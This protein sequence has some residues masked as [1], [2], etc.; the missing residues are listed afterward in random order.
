[1]SL[2][3]SIHENKENP[4]PSNPSKIVEAYGLRKCPKLVEQCQSDNIVVRVNALTVLCD[5][6]RNPSSIRE[7]C[8]AGAINVLAGMITH[9][10]YMCRFKSSKALAIAAED[11]NGLLSIIENDAVPKILAGIN[12]DAQ[13][14]RSNVYECMYHCSRT[15]NGVMAAVKAGA[16]LS[17]VKG[18]STEVDLLKP[19]LLQA[20]ASGAKTVE[21]LASCLECNAVGVCVDMLDRGRPEEVSAQ[22]AKTLG[23]LCFSDEAKSQSISL[24]VIPKIVE[25]LAERRNSIRSACST[26]LMAIT[27]SDEG[28]MQMSSCR[29]AAAVASLLTDSDLIIKMN[30]LKVIANIAVYPAIRLEL[31]NH[32]TCQSSIKKILDGKDVRLKKHAKIALDAVMWQA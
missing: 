17:F 13:E 8:K 22:A 19:L 1:M 25:L 27:T 6:F 15:A 9:P 3:M 26:A 20:I 28:K 31:R 21:G 30:A 11:A 32:D 18:I 16:I 29:G 23:F 7:C 12:D 2:I 5:E 10:D 14:V 24:G 4:D